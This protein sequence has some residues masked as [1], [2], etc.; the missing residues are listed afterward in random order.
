MTEI[1]GLVLLVLY[2]AVAA[3]EANEETETVAGNLNLRLKSA[4]WSKV[5]LSNLFCL[6]LPP[7][8]RI[9]PEPLF[10]IL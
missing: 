8:I 7:P 10:R 1:L 9:L 4:A 6:A 2:F 3:K 5:I